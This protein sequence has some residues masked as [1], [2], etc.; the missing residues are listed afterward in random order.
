MVCL[1]HHVAR[2]NMR[3]RECIGIRVDRAT[4]NPVSFKKLKPMCRR[5]P[6]CDCFDPLR[7]CLVILDPVH[8]T[9]VRGIIHPLGVPEQLAQ[10]PKQSIRRG[11][12]RNVAIG[13]LDRLIRGAQPV[14]VASPW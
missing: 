4:R 1:D 8:I 10:K 2:D 12:D 13:A 6:R 5:V 3:I 14:W 7:E 11:P 9:G